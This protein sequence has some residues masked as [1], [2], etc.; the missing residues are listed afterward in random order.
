[1]EITHTVDAC[2]YFCISRAAAA[3]AKTNAV[4]N[5]TDYDDEELCGYDEYMT[6]GNIS[7]SY[8]GY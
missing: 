8:I 1:M 2:R 3:E 5:E 7:D 6:G 4:A